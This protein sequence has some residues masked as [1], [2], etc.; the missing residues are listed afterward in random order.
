MNAAEL[1]DPQLPFAL[2]AANRLGAPLARRLSLEPDALCAA[3]EKRTGL[4]DFGSARFREPLAVL[5][6]ALEQEARLTALGR[7][8]A[9]IQLVGLLSTRL[10]ALDLLRRRPEIE[11]EAIGAPIVI[12][13]MPR[14]G[15]TALQRL[16]SRDPRLRSLPYWE[17]LAPLPDGD[18]TERGADPAPRIE[19]ARRGLRFLHWAA[20]RMQAM[21]E[22]DALE[23]DEEIWLLALDLATMLFEATW[24]V[25]SFRAWYERADLRE[26]YAFLR[27][28]LQ[29]LQWYRPGE[30]WLLK[31]PQHM[32]QLPVLFETFPGALVVQTHR[33]P[34]EVTA[35]FV[36][37]AC[38]GRR[39]NEAHPD[40]GAIAR[41]WAGR[42]EAMLRRSLEGRAGLP[43]ERFVDVRFADLVADP[44]AVVRRI[45]AAAGLALG[46]DVEAPMR[47]WLAANPR[48]KHGGH[49]YRLEDFGLDPAERRRALAFYGDALK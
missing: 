4:A 19:R 42:I 28:M 29:I 7:V 14:T 40:P 3:A 44:L 13:G 39:M 20:P 5:A 26:G 6:R 12:L 30:R 16:L 35:S 27:R 22:M 41:Y 8:S 33:D 38:Y 23:P 49:S 46:A 34:L 1:A 21:H 24:N 48:G 37:M 17:A 2:R 36:S 25:P 15:T 47:A 11:A 18:A 9:R 10:R 45:Y 31:S 43:P 32:E